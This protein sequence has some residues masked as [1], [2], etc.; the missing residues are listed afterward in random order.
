MS[1]G[2]QQPLCPSCRFNQPTAYY[3]AGVF[4]AGRQCF[5]HVVSFPDAT[6]CTL[7]EREAGAD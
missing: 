7:Y 3:L 2:A 5:H 1:S 6:H 4:T